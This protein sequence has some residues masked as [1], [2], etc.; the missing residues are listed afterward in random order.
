[1]TQQQEKYAVADLKRLTRDPISDYPYSTTWVITPTLDDTVPDAIRSLHLEVWAPHPDIPGHGML[2]ARLSPGM[3]H[4]SSLLGQMLSLD[5]P[6]AEDETGDENHEGYWTALLVT[7]KVLPHLHRLGYQCALAFNRDQGPTWT[8][9][10]AE[11]C[12]PVAEAHSQ[13]DFLLALL[14]LIEKRSHG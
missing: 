1:M 3:N 11:P 2:V 8:I 9:Y 13:T 10:V 6:S 12:Y 5:L 7:K 14:D 4:H